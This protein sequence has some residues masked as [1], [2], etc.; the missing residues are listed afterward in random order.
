MDST[1]VTRRVDAMDGPPILWVGRENPGW[2]GRRRRL[3]IQVLKGETW[4]MRHPRAR[5]MA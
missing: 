3:M 5:R 1:Y 2:V 4:S